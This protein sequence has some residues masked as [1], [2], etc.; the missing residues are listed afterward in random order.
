MQNE[1]LLSLNFKDKE[2]KYNILL[3]QV[4]SLIKEEND[5]IANLANVTAAIKENFKFLWI[6]F[7]RV[8]KKELIL[9][10]FQG[11][12]ACT[13]IPYGKG[14]CGKAWKEK[15]TIIVNNVHNFP[16]HIVCNS[17]S[18][19]EIVVP[20]YNKKGKIKYILD[21]DSEEKNRFDKIDKIYLEK[22]ANILTDKIK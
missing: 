15:K 8:I 7:Y 13:R 1:D 11:E 22:L 3:K 16:G 14:V 6:G 5:E 21:I 19:S 12:V 18:C 4:E 10:P 17:K 20:V 9:G 2:L